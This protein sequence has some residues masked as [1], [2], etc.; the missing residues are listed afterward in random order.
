MR[1]I[2]VVNLVH[3]DGTNFYPIDFRIYSPEADGKT[4]N[5]HFQDMF[6]ALLNEKKLLAKTIL[7][8]S[9][10][11]SIDNL[12][13]IHRSQRYFV[14]TLKSN[15]MVSLSSQTGYCHLEELEWSEAQL[16]DGQLVK[17][18]ELPFKVRLFKVVATNGDIEWMITN[19][20]GFISAQVTKQASDVRWQIEQL[21]RELKQLTGSEK[22]QCRKARAQRT[23][24]ALC[25]QAWLA[26]RVKATSLKKTM[27]VVINEL[28]GDFL[29][30]QLRLCPIPAL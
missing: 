12:K 19:H 23:H 1:G 4:K 11:A 8:D 26:I 15:R 5:D 21:H 17:L 14:T 9:W 13:L 16:V 28:Y 30:A 29:R 2:G 3:S 6:L 18:K 10:Y 22:C 20:P 24:L 7:F 25:Y 27:Y